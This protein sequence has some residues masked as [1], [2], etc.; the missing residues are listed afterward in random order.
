MRIL[1]LSCALLLAASP[2]FAGPGAAE[3]KERARTAPAKN[4][5]APK[6]SDR[7]ARPA[8]TQGQATWPKK[9]QHRMS[10]YAR[11]GR[12][13]D[14]EGDLQEQVRANMV[15]TRVQDVQGDRIEL[16]RAKLSENKRF[17]SRNA[18]LARRRG[19]ESDQ[20]ER[21]LARLTRSR[22]RADFR[23]Q[24]LI[25]AHELAELKR[26]KEGYARFG[27]PLE[28]SGLRMAD[29]RR[30]E[31]GADADERKQDRRK[32]SDDRGDRDPRY[33]DSRMH[34]ERERED[35]GER[36]DE[37][38]EDRR[39]DRAAERE[40]AEEDRKLD[41]EGEE[42]DRK[43][44]RLEEAEERSEDAETRSEERSDERTDDRA[45]EKTIRQAEENTRDE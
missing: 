4:V 29:K 20:R 23:R 15:R 36:H 25:P 37:L 14:R 27:S 45:D 42:D 19:V 41:R 6:A 1:I 18:V 26:Y 43:L 28:R 30:N 3:G 9:L 34:G 5:A 32:L 13:L 40:G 7:S 38:A 21:N 31:R 8:L 44:D 24:M 33:L 16:A 11:F 39:A 22:S 35:H 12:T 10:R 2:T 17:A